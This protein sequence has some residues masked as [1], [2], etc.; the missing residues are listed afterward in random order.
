MLQVEERDRAMLELGADDSLCRQP[1]PS[2]WKRTDLSRSSTPMVTT[3][4]RGLMADTSDGNLETGA[5]P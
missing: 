4:M 3:V 2:R 5:V 1:K